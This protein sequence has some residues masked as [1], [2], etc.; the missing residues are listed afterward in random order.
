MYNNNNNNSNNNYRSNNTDAYLSESENSTDKR[1]SDKNAMGGIKALR[2]SYEALEER[3]EK[4]TNF[5][6]RFTRGLYRDKGNMII[7]SKSAVLNK[8]FGSPIISSSYNN[9]E[10]RRALQTVFHD[11]IMETATSLQQIAHRGGDVLSSYK[12]YEL[13]NKLLSMPIK[14]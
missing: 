1:M 14:D 7:D 13:T 6:S 12:V 11:N 4:T 9:E 3:P 10:N 2:Q 5:L 8:Y